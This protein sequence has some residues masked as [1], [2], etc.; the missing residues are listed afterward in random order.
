MQRQR[1]QNDTLSLSYLDS[2]RAGKTVIA[3]HA[4]WMEGVTFT[5]LIEALGS[6]WRVVALDQRG[7]GYSDHGTSYT[8]NDY[9]SDLKAL[10]EHLKLPDPVVI[11]GNSLGGV[12]AYQFAA[13]YPT[14]VQAIIIEDIGVEIDGDFNFIRAWKGI[15]KTR[16]DLSTCIGSGL[17]PYLQDSFR[18]TDLGWQLAFE[19]EEILMSLNS[20]KG[21]YWL[22]WLS[23]DCPALLIRG[24]ESK[25]TTQSHLEQMCSR[26]AHTELK[27][28]PGGHVVH[29][30]NPEGFIE[31]IKEFLKNL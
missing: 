4:H 23:T 5:S 19:P 9:L 7:H 18:E 1:F 28:L 30:D 29:V 24:N 12:N 15:F 22:D 2:G 14:L 13:R 10:V 8:R 3:L 16:A 31:A 27:N 21:D 6:S 25:V 17:L 11:L 20:I 26:R